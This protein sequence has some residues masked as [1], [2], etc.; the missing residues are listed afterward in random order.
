VVDR[1]TR[2]PEAIPLRAT[3]T[4]DCVEALISGWVACFGVPAAITSDRG[5]QFSS[6]V[7]AGLCQRLGISHHSTTAYHPQSNGMVEGFYRQL[8]DALRARLQGQDWVSQLPWVLLG[9]RSAP[10]EKANISSAEIVYGTSLTLP[11]EFLD[12]PEAEVDRWVEKLRS[13]AASFSPPSTAS[14]PVMEAAEVPRQLQS[15][16]HMYVRGD[17]A[18][19]PLAAKYDGPF[20]VVAKA[21]KYFRIQR[22]DRVETVFVDR[23]KP[24]LGTGPVAPA[25][26]PARGRPRKAVQ[27]DE[28]VLQ[29]RDH[30]LPAAVWGACVTYGDLMRVYCV[31][32]SASRIVGILGM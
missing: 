1:S 20:L 10:K 13:E 11:G 29:E 23:L 32:K 26:P 3:S 7:L 8:K 18:R 25:S 27:K 24:H 28:D 19:P 4:G 14:G 6:G 21:A 9:L 31:N 17:G 12:T 16:Q 30:V 22:G 15:C 5:V 2:W